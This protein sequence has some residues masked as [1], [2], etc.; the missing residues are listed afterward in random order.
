MILNI[1]D[2]EN[3][4]FIFMLIIVLVK[5]KM[6]WDDFVNCLSNFLVICLKSKLNCLN[7]LFICLNSLEWFIILF[8][9]F[10]KLFE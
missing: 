4:M 2:W 6:I 1:I 8:E 7:D 10:I 9:W 5:I 3:S